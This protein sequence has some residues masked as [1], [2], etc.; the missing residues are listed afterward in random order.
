MMNVKV[1]EQMVT[2]GWNDKSV[3]FGYG[4]R[5]D[6]LEKGKIQVVY[7]LFG[8]GYADITTSQV[9]NSLIAAEEYENNTELVQKVRNYSIDYLLENQLS[10]IEGKIRKIVDQL[11]NENREFVELI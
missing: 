4:S 5:R 11:E 1:K 2:K 9:K 6:Y 10:D 8:G 3:P 7:N